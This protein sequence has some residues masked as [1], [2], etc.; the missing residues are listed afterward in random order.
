MA[1]KKSKPKKKTGKKRKSGNKKAKQSLLRVAVKWLFVTGLWFGIGIVL[2]TA[3]YAAELP[4]IIDNPKLERQTAIKVL[5]RDNSSLA[6]YGEL[7]GVNLTIDDVPNHLIYAVMAVEDRRFYQHFGIDPL[8]IA[9]AMVRNVTAGRVAQGGSTITQQL[10]KNLFLSHERTLKRKIQ[11]AILALW[12]EHELTKDEILTAYLNRVYLGSGAYGIDAAAQTYFNKKAQDISLYESAMLAGL[13]KAP[14]RYSPQSNPTLAASRA[15]VVLGA[16]QDAG[17]ITEAEAKA[18][19]IKGQAAMPKPTVGQGERYFTD[20]IISNIDNMIGTP[21]NNLTIKTTLHPVIQRAAEQALAEILRQ[22]GE[23]HEVTQGA[24][25]VLRRDG[26]IL[27]M[28]GGADYKQSQ[29]NRATQARRPPG[30]SFKPVVYLTALQHG[31]SPEDLIDDAPITTGKYRPQNF[32]NQY[33]GEVPLI[34]ALSRSLNS[35]AFKLAQDVG[36]DEIIKTARNLGITSPLEYDMS[37]A[38]GSSGIPMLEMLRAYCTLANDGLAVTPYS[39]EKITDEEGSLLYI[40]SDARRL[41]RAI[42]ERSVH[43]LRRMMQ[44]TIEN[45]TGRGA[46]LPMLAAG[47]TGTSQEHRDAWFIGFTDDY[48]VGVWMGNDDNSPMKKVTGGSLPA[49]V[50]RDTMMAAYKTGGAYTASDRPEE[51]KTSSRTATEPKKDTRF[52]SSIFRD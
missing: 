35:A 27:A 23:E 28:V 50:W 18:Q 44:E 2:L 38:L 3:W 30:S 46:R 45:G 39:I 34:F 9:R 8:G 36:I 16:M 29:F 47:K 25:I 14:S 21:G 4:K 49:L 48:I 17:Y 22:N 24:V 1:T 31:W 41:R 40:R 12:L 19:S 7:K 42:D 33:Y 15:Q 32:K 43:E 6:V 5:A 20:W 26:A 37:I 51:I 10:A 11:E 13:L 52:F